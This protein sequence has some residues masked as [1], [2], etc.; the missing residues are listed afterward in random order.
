LVSYVR[1]KVRVTGWASGGQVG[2]GGNTNLLGKLVGYNGPLL[3]AMLT[4]D[5]R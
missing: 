2:L 1:E 4:L 3:G 5:T